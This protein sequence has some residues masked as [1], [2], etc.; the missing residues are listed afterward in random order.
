MALLILFFF[1]LIDFPRFEHQNLQ[2]EIQKKNQVWNPSSTQ[3][4]AL[5]RIIIS[6]EV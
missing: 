1:L 3:T 4:F 6:F 2:K 5:K